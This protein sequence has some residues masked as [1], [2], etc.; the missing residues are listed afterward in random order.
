[1]IFEGYFCDNSFLE[2]YMS[3]YSFSFLLTTIDASRCLGLQ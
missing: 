1:M 3:S 2:F